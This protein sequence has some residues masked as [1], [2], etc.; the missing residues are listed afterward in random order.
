VIMSFS[1]R[2]M[3]HRTHG[4]SDCDFPESPARAHAGLRTQGDC[5]SGCDKPT[6]RNGRERLGL[7]LAV[8]DPGT[9]TTLLSSDFTTSFSTTAT[10]HNVS[11]EPERSKQNVS[12]IAS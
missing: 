6:F 1:D 8:S 9:H 12:K 11:L 2:G 3:K 7:L 5:P 4:R 10:R